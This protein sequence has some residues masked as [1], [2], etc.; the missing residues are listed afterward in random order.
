MIR[1]YNIIYRQPCGKHRLC[2]I[3]MSEDDAYD[4]NR[5]RYIYPGN[6][7]FGNDCLFIYHDVAPIENDCRPDTSV[8]RKLK[9]HRSTPLAL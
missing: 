9:I 4:A 5:L 8:R 2:A 3:Q 1:K 6:S 7:I